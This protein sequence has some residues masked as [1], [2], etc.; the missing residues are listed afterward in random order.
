MGVSQQA[1]ANL[2]GPRP[3]QP[4]ATTDDLGICWNLATLFLFP[5]P[6]LVFPFLLLTCPSSWEAADSLRHHG[7]MEKNLGFRTFQ[8]LVQILTLTL[9][10]PVTR[11]SSLPLRPSVSSS[12]SGGNNSLHWLTHQAQCPAYSTCSMNLSAASF[13][14]LP[15]I[16]FRCA[17]PHLSIFL[18]CPKP[19]PTAS[20]H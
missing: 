4:K 20:P 10:S 15:S 17:P 19:T 12:V 16:P 7:V 3:S 11:G 8:T 2:G 14:F 1:R 6:M 9:I 5:P 18:S 13:V